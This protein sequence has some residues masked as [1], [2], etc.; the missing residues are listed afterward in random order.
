MSKPIL[1]DL[2]ERYEKNKINIDKHYQI[3]FR[4]YIERIKIQKKKGRS[5]GDRYFVFSNFK[6]IL[7]KFL[8]DNGF[9]VEDEV[10]L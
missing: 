2:I 3:F 10:N 4:E 9:N 8:T 1:N 7:K 5:K 6:P